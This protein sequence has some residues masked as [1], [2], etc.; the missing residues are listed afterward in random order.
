M[1]TICDSFCREAPLH[2]NR[3]M[4]KGLLLTFCSFRNAVEF[5]TFLL[6]ENI[7]RYAHASSI[8]L[9]LFS[10]FYTHNSGILPKKTEPIN[11]T[12]RFRAL[13]SKRAHF[14]QQCQMQHWCREQSWTCA[15]R[16][17]L[18]HELG[19]GSGA[20][21]AQAERKGKA[22]AQQGDREAAKVGG[23][24]LLSDQSLTCQSQC[25]HHRVRLG[26]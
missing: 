9:Y 6:V 22:A 1:S 19:R 18:G 3:E 4:I 8:C 16:L 14:P 25:G 23:L 21:G 26:C 20:A 15:P 13:I 11:Y 24:C 12:E 2:R 10:Y 7:T 17:C 5:E